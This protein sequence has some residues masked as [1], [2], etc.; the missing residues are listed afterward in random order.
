MIRQT[1]YNLDIFHMIVRGREEV[2]YDKF[3]LRFAKQ[4]GV[5]SRLNIAWELVNIASSELLI[6]LRSAVSV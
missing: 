2:I 3:E 1:T 5:E 4:D 6:D